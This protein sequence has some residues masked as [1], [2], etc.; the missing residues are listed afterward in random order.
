MEGWPSVSPSLILSVSV[1]FE[2][3][4][5][6]STSPRVL[7]LYATA[8][9]G[10]R[11]AA[12]A[13]ADQLRAADA[14]VLALDVMAYTHPVF[15]TLYVGGGLRL[16]TR[17]P[18]LYGLA[19]RATDQRLINRLLR[20]PRLRTQQFSTPRLQ[21]ALRTFQPDVVIST[22]F[23]AS[24]L[25]AGWRRTG[26]LA[27]P[28][29]TVV[30]DFEPHYMWQ[31]AGTDVYCVPTNEAV[32]RLARDGIDRSIVAATG[33]PIDPAFAER[34]DRAA[35]R[36]RIQL[37]RDRAVVLI[38]GGGLGVGRLDQLA[39]QLIAQPLEA[40]SVFI[41]GQN[42]ALR[43]RLRSLNSERSLNS[44]WMVRGLLDNMP[45]WLAAA[46]V[47]ISKAGGLAASELLAAGVPTIVPPALSGH[48][49]L[50]AAY[51]AAT[52]AARLASSPQQAIDEAR[53]ILSDPIRQRMMIDAA[54]RAAKPT[55]AA[56][57]ARIAL[58]L[59]YPFRKSASPDFDGAC[60]TLRRLA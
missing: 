17:L 48:E 31:H 43:R 51:F 39:Q 33:I 19:Y 36:D 60:T 4:R 29:I 9:A 41:T 34:P 50:N 6:V 32:D 28:L 30:T 2:Y 16:I 1:R 23:M 25:C 11:R 14:R 54:Q 15:R 52:G 40:Q 12:E 7:M 10:H 45:D 46:D 22:H 58:R 3:N 56:D 8:G 26:A 55:A 42:R 49:G 20:G 27:A 57:V 53:A 13:V 37:D 21:Q 18:R 5:R 47:A 44:R 24:E 38:M 59:A 35:V